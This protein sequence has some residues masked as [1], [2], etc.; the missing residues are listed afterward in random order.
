MGDNAPWRH[1][2]VP[3]FYLR[4]FACADDIN[5]VVVLEQHG[6][7]LVSDRKSIGGIGYEE[8]LHDY[9]DGGRP[10]SIEGDLNRLIETPFS[11][12]P[13]WSKINGGMCDALDAGDAL[14]L[15]HFARHLQRR[16]LE[17]LQFI[18]A[19]HE[20]VQAKDKIGEMNEEKREMHRWIEASAGNA[21]A[22]FR[23]GA[24]DM[25]EPADA[26]RINV[27]LC[28]SP[29]ALRSSTNPTLIV[30]F[31]GRQSVFGDFFNNLRTWWLSLD[32]HW[33]VFIV[34][35]GPSG[36]SKSDLPADSA[37]VINRQY[38]IQ[39]QNSLSVRYLIADDSYVAEDLEWVGYRIEQKTTRGFRY[40]K[41]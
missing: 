19:E 21:H 6:D 30:S 14:P 3:Q 41:T 2:Y 17:T 5:R 16:N 4:R 39:H 32:R 28:R 18:R 36:F 35:G 22:L 24:V 37:R 10:A 11:N 7:R 25:L 1:H 15:Y 13:T 27:M 9:D 20:R 38:L 34:A 26:S 8:Y 23:A 31:P 29:I 33:G 12:G 40:R